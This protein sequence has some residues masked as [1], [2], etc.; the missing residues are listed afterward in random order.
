M[1]DNR[2]LDGRAVRDRIL[3]EVGERVRAASATHAI[4]RLVSISIGEHKE[5]AVYVRGQARAAQKVGL[6]F[7]SETWPDTLTQQECKARL[8][9]MMSARVRT[10]STRT[11]F[12]TDGHAQSSPIV[13]GVID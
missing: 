5:A 10:C 11:S 9:A 13:R 3:S 6:R 8:V 12:N 1:K 4:G 2:L 7:D